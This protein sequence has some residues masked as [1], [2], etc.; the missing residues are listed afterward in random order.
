MFL[1]I[2]KTSLISLILVAVTITAGNA[3]TWEEQWSSLVAAAKSEGNLV[4]SSPAGNV[5]RAQLNK[6]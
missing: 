4:M 1:N 6:F 2:V 3:A 5:W